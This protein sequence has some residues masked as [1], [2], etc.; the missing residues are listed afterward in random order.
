VYL[1]A[2]VLYHLVETVLGVEPPLE[3][4]NTSD[5][6]VAGGFFMTVYLIM[7]IVLGLNMLIAMSA[8]DLPSHAPPCAFAHPSHAP[9]L[10]S[11]LPSHAPPRAAAL[12]PTRRHYRPLCVCRRRIHSCL[13]SDDDL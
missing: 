9:P 4:L 5:R 1:E 2:D 13:P 11:A 3:C 7:V 8:S 6:A 10:P 12:S